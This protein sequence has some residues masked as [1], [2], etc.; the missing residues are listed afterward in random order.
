ML[1]EN[2]KIQHIL[3]NNKCDASILSKIYNKKVQKQFVE[4]MKWAKVTYIDKETKCITKIS[5][6]TS[7]KVTF[8]IDNTTEN[9]LVTL[10][11]QN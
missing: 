9:L 11:N 3:T 7:V 10:H 8:T 6:N 4:R 2:N 1:K 5:K